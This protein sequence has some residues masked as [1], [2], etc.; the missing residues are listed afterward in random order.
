MP[1]RQRTG[2]TI[3][4]LLVVIT[5]IGILAALLLPAVLGARESANQ[6]TCRNNLSQLA[7]AVI[8]EAT[9]K[10]HLPPALSWDPDTMARYLADPNNFTPSQPPFGWLQPI[11]AEYGEQSTY[12]AIL[13]L[14]K[15]GNQGGGQVHTAAGKFI[16]GLICPSN[17]PDN[18]ESAWIHYRANCGRL[19][20]PATAPYDHQAN[21]VFDVRLVTNQKNW[22]RNSLSNIST[23]LTILLAENSFEVDVNGDGTPDQPVLW[24]QAHSTANAADIQNAEVQQAIFW[25]RGS[26]LGIPDEY[27]HNAPL[28][29]HAC[30]R[31]F[32]TS[33]CVT[34]ACGRSPT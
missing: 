32:S 18:L 24:N 3:V 16:E 19:D 14:A 10:Q 12:E 26:T 33:P 29:Q 23:S 13:D 2:F 31:N 1:A 11:L 17:K 5:V 28:N 15:Q 20:N 30:T 22:Y 4:E 25:Q 9:T 21:G 34:A 7:K 27:G 6:V 8:N